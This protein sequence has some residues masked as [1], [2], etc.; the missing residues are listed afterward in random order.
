MH[1]E[2]E[3]KTF[4]SRLRELRVQARLTQ[5]RLAENADISCVYVNKLE[6]GLAMPSLHVLNRLAQ[7]LNTDAASLLAPPRERSADHLDP[8]PAGATS[9]Y[10]ALY[11][12]GT[13]SRLRHL[14]FQSTETPIPPLPAAG[15]KP[16]E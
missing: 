4:G 11:L 7:S 2:A 8:S 14:V 12:G 13:K 3:Y 10:M 1:P 5:A 15:R 16:R 9:P 6:R